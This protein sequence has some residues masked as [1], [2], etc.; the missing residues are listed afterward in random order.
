M[1]KSIEIVAIHKQGLTALVSP[2]LFAFLPFLRSP[3]T[4]GRMIHP[5]K[6]LYKSALAK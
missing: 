4:A 3:G 2:F 5:N 6:N 1:N